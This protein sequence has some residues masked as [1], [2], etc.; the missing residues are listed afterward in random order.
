MIISGARAIVKRVP[1]GRMHDE[2]RCMNCSFCFGVK[3]YCRQPRSRLSL[4]RR[5]SGPFYEHEP[6][7]V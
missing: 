6:L 7:P 4:V 3:V 1:R 2:T 5:S